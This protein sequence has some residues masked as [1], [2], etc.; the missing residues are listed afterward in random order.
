MGDREHAHPD[1]VRLVIGDDGARGQIAVEDQREADHQRDE[2]PELGPHRQGRAQ[3]QVERGGDPERDQHPAG[4]SLAPAQHPDAERQRREQEQIATA[5]AGTDRR[6]LAPEQDDP[7]VQACEGDGEEEQDLFDR[8]SEQARAEHVGG[9]EVPVRPGRQRVP[10][11]V[12]HRDDE[13][14]QER[15]KI[16]AT[17]IRRRPAREQ[18]RH[19]DDDQM[20]DQVLGTH[21]ADYSR[22]GSRPAKGSVGARLVSGTEPRHAC[23]WN[24]TA[25]AAMP[26]SMPRKTWACSG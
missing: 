7:R 15:R 25:A 6:I 8:Q 3:Q 9:V 21:A 23:S 18:E 26:R 10:P 2:G 4:V 1:L 13:A 19:R 14:G 12:G 17:K 16:Q 22:S 5:Q 11:E 24:A 20:E